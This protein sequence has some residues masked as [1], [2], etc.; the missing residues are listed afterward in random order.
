MR[1]I[2]K[3]LF[4]GL[5]LLSY[6]LCFCQD[7][8]ITGL[9]ELGTKAGNDHFTGDVYINMGAAAAD[10]LNTVMGKVT[11][12]PNARTHWH[13]HGTGQILI[14]TDGEGLYQEE[15]KPVVLIHKG[16]V[17]KCPKNVKHW[18]GATSYGSMAHSAIVPN[19]KKGA[20]EWFQSVTDQ[21]YKSYTPMKN[22][23]K[24]GLT[25]PAKRNVEK[26]WPLDSVSSL[27]KTDPEFYELFTNFT[28]GE[29]MEI[30]GLDDRKSI[31]V[32]LGAA[33]ATQSKEV[34]LKYTEAGLEIGMTPVEIKEVLY[35][36][37]P[38]AGYAKVAEILEATN[39]LFTEKG[40]LLPLEPQ[41]TITQENRLEKGLAVQKAIFGERI[42]HMYKNPKEGQKH[43]PEYLSANCFGDY[44]T[45]GGLDLA[46]RELLNFA[47]ISSLG[48]A[49][50]QLAGHIG[51]NIA[52]GNTK[53]ML[54]TA[55]TRMVPFIGYPR[56]LNAFKV[57]N[58]TFE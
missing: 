2:L 44:Y 51:G 40:I 12:M 24:V 4:L 58:H 43:I 53:E 28:M 14:V 10:G 26:F 19:L 32:V 50:S 16:D 27:A 18:H 22:T 42:E 17:V 6:K 57:L 54:V 21:E 41:G 49:E 29:T 25:E 1:R 5:L 52:V 23:I 11:F 45:R 7:Y 20:A 39:K 13:R 55:I 15:G 33:I 3:I 48:D 37:A 9:Q 35:H 8:N 30:A 46:D 56:S 31:I 38:Y 47:I 36:G 34:F